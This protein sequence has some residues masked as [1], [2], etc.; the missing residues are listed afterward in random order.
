[1]SLPHRTG[2]RLPAKGALPALFIINTR[3]NASAGFVTV[4]PLFLLPEQ[5]LG[6][7][8]E[9]CAFVIIYG[10]PIY[11]LANLVPEAEH[12]LL[13]FLS[14]WLAVYSAR[15]MALWVAALLPTLQ[16]SAF[17][18]NVLFTSFYLSGGFVISLENLWTGKTKLL[19]PEPPMASI[20]D[21]RLCPA[22]ET[23]ALPLPWQL[24]SWVVT[25]RSDRAFYISFSI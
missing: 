16:L 1:M 11:W 9:H 4:I 21:R 25:V 10:V 24:P 7:L 3:T 13:N 22:R 23:S 17:F 8:P 2:R 18:G 12:F 20:S 14:V 15:T 19:Q 6:E 5:V